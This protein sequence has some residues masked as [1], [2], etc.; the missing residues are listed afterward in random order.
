MPAVLDDQTIYQDIRTGRYDFADFGSCEGGSID[1]CS[2]RF[3]AARGL[4][5]DILQCEVDKMRARGFDALCADITTFDCPTASFRF[6]SMMDFL[7][8][9]PDYEVVAKILTTARRIARDFLFIRHPSFEDEHYLNAVGLKQFWTDWPGPGGH[10]AKLTIAD[11]TQ[12][13][14]KLGFN[15]YAIAYRCPAHDSNDDCILPLGAPPNEHH[16]DA[17]RHG[18]KPV[19]AFPRPVYGQID[20]FVALRP[21]PNPEWARTILQFD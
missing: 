13:F 6:V 1:Y 11:F 2:R 12:I 19:V 21:M 7:E 15:Q 10:T 17:A 8:H 9:L 16:Y 5:I 18:P 14:S 4:G 3:D 20:I